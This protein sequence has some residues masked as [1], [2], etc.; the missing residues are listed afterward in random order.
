MQGQ[1]V[2]VVG[3]SEGIGLAVAQAAAQAGA[4]VTIAGRHQDKLDAA[5]AGSELAT[6]RLDAGDEAG[7]AAYFAACEPWDHL[8]TLTGGRWGPMAAAQTP[9]ETTQKAFEQ[10]FWTQY[11][12]AK[13][14]A[15]KVKPGGS[16]I[17]TSGQAS[18]RY[19]PGLAWLS[20][21][22]AGLEALAHGLALELAEAKVRVN[23]IC[24]GLVETGVFDRMPPDAKQGFLAGAAG[25]LTVGFVAKP[26]DLATAYLYLMN[27][28]Y[29]NASVVDVD[30]GGPR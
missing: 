16:I 29:S 9:V 10:K 7:V 11:R 1:R 2:L 24:P 3:A 27:S 8:V 26:A 13:H 19:L 22:N 30:G 12:V 17:L 20:A 28:P 15:G 6:L 5:A 25:R 21:I 18:R 23:V 14:G 4:A